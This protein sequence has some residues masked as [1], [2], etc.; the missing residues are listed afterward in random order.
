MQSGEA[1]EINY[2]DPSL[3]R[4]RERMLAYT[5]ALIPHTRDEWVQDAAETFLDLLAYA[6]DMYAKLIEA[7]ILLDTKYPDYEEP[8]EATGDLIMGLIIGWSSALDKLT[9]S[10]NRK[11]TKK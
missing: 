8:D 9:G 11:V 2:Q 4:F 6:E 3:E 1:A 5:T 10:T 7:E